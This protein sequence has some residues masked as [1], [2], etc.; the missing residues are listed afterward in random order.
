MKYSRDSYYPPLLS[1]PL[2]HRPCTLKKYKPQ[3]REKKREVKP[4]W[5]EWNKSLLR[6]H[7]MTNDAY[8]YPIS[9][10]VED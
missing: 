10:E 5:N 3:I 9:S 7:V 8:T 4:N 2:P 6:M 1:P